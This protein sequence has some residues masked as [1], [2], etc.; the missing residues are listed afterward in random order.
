MFG[1]DDVGMFHPVILTRSPYHPSTWCAKAREPTGVI[2]PMGRT[3]G[4]PIRRSKHLRTSCPSRTVRGGI[5]EQARMRESRR[6][7][8][9]NGVETNRRTRAAWHREGRLGKCSV[10]GSGCGRPACDSSQRNTPHCGGTGH[11][12][13][14]SPIPYR[15]N[16]SGPI[17]L[18]KSLRPPA[19]GRA[20]S[21]SA[22]R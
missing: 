11:P 15:S 1:A 4:Q 7:I 17:S 14:A 2:G 5:D 18:G 16:R 10:V 13:S 8:G 3:H 22:R 21:F 9:S 20:L 19:K 6:E 12:S